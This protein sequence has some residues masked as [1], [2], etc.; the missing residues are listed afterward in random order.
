MAVKFRI[1]YPK[2][3]NYDIV[4][5]VVGGL[6]DDFLSPKG[7]KIKIIC[8]DEGA[9][10]WR[11]AFEELPE[12]HPAQDAAY[13]LVNDLLYGSKKIR[14]P[15]V[16]FRYFDEELKILADGESPPDGMAVAEVEVEERDDDVP[17]TYVTYL[18]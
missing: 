9:G 3:E 12:D 2:I 17:D 14:L 15:E 18:D 1:A 5:T 10:D 7:K 11:P 6:F 13:A 8:I 4:V 16:D